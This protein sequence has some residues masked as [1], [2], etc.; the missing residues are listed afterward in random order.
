MGT[1]GLVWYARKSARTAANAASS[2]SNAAFS[3]PAMMYSPAPANS[4]DSSGLSALSQ[5]PTVSNTSPSN[6]SN[7]IGSPSISDLISSA[8]ASTTK[9]SAD[10]Y[11]AQLNSTDTA[12][13]AALEAKLG[14]GSSVNIKHDDTGTTIYSTPPPPVVDPIT[15]I[16]QSVLGRTPDPVGYDYWSSQLAGGKNIEQVKAAVAYSPEAQ[17]DSVFSSVLGRAPDAAG[18]AYWSSQLAGGKSIAQITSE[19]SAQKAAGAK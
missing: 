5:Y 12:T 18:A 19:I 16:Y 13:I 8:I 6:P 7:A 15:S 14:V 9:S 2:A 3:T 17:I 1:L 11:A 4:Y 10:Q